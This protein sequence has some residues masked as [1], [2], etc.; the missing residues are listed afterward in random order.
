M[1]AAVLIFSLAAI[2]LLAA[3]V[4]DILEYR[5]YRRAAT[6]VIAFGAAMDQ[7]FKLVIGHV[8]RLG[9]HTGELARAQN[10]LEQQNIFL[11]TII[12]IHSEALG[13]APLKRA[14]KLHEELIEGE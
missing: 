12:Q 11:N 8:E 2:A 14:H 5:R 6:S 7:Q 4:V 3:I 1:E 13:L 10:L 9:E